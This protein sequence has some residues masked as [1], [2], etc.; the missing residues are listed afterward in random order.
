MR[1]REL[2]G[3]QLLL[4]D[5]DATQAESL[6]VLLRTQGWTAEHCQSG[7]EALAHARLGQFSLALV[8]AGLSDVDGVELVRHLRARSD[9]PIVLLSGRRQLTDKLLGLDAGADD[10]LTKPFEPAELVA[11]IRAHLRRVSPPVEVGHSLRV[12]PLH[13][14][15]TRHSFTCGGRPIPLSPRE[16]DL[17]VALAAADGRAVSRRELFATVWGPNFVGDAGALDVYIRRLRGKFEADPAHPTYLH[18]IRGFG[19]RL[20]ADYEEYVAA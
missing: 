18:T 5:N 14:D 13:V 4:V 20:A 17:L 12:G 19:F 15:V 16:F 1:N 3:R 7:G 8:D 9:L 11:R 2:F 6:R 10:Y